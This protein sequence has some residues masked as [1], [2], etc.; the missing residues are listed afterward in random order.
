MNKGKISSWNAFSF[1]KN[2]EQQKSSATSTSTR[3]SKGFAWDV[4]L[5]SSC[6]IIEIFSVTLLFETTKITSFKPRKPQDIYN[7][8]RLIL[9]VRST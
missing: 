8:I 1:K 6:I 4:F 2:G 3:A 9:T 7:N 5:Y